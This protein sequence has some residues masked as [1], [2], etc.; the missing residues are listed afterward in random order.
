[1]RIS[2]RLGSS[3]PRSI[4]HR[5]ERR[6]SDRNI[7]PVRGGY[8]VPCVEGRTKSILASYTVQRSRFGVTATE[9]WSDAPPRCFERVAK[10]FLAGSRKT[11]KFTGYGL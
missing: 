5:F 1:M 3:P 10:P 2:A 11:D 9:F 8:E 6:I 4:L 7:Q